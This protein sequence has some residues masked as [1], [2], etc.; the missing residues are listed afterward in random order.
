[1]LPLRFQAVI[2]DLDG[3]LIDTETLYQAAF[4]DSLRDLGWAMG[5]AAYAQL[6]GLPGS[7]R[8]ALLP[9]LFGAHFPCD[10]FLALYR[11]KRAALLGR[12]IA[13]KRGVEPL[14]D[15]LD[16]RRLPKAIATAASRDTARANLAATGLLD[17]FD[18][19]VTRDDVAR[20]KPAP[21][22]IL[23]AAA[24][25]GVAP[26]AC[27]V[28]E[29]S[30][31]GV[32]AAEAAGAPVVLVPDRVRPTAVLRARCAAV[33]ESL[34]DVTRMLAATGAPRSARRPAEPV[35]RR[36]VP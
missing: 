28:V 34:D 20:G 33:V 6:V 8:R 36:A 24:A 4:R 5:E 7:A 31:H 21:D 2:L 25:M 18:I 13:L 30:P 12:G 10:R 19:V 27:L 17:R 22:C 23:F 26:A 16:A 3:T 35:E 1:M 32:L 9:S 15:W 14:L 11:E 29:D